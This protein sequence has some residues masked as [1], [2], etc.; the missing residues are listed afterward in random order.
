MHVMEE[1]HAALCSIHHYLLERIIGLKRSLLIHC[2]LVGFYAFII[3]LIFF[4]V[5]CLCFSVV[6]IGLGMCLGCPW[7]YLRRVFSNT[8]LDFKMLKLGLGRM[9]GE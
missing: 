1:K 8:T 4:I 6:G 7:I 2:L 3:I 9:S 5:V